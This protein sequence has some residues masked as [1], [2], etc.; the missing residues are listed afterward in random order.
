MLVMLSQVINNKTN[1]IN[2]CSQEKRKKYS[3]QYKQR[4][5]FTQSIKIIRGI[6]TVLKNNRK[7]FF[8]PQQNNLFTHSIEMVDKEKQY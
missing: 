1:I 4:K 7:Y 6:I 5:L 8:W 3:L 2:S